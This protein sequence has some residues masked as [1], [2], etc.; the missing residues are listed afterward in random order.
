V[1]SAARLSSI[2]MPPVLTMMPPDGG[3]IGYLKR[4][5]AGANRPFTGHERALILR[6][7]YGWAKWR[8]WFGEG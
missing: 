1:N 3:G 6:K 5:A 8:A 4:R 7:G 2:V